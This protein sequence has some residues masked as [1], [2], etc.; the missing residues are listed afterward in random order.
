M[1]GQAGSANLLLGR[2]NRVAMEETELSLKAT[3]LVL[4]P[5]RS[6]VLPIGALLD[7]KR[8]GSGEQ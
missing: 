1:I 6:P 7:I 2:S 5:L 8:T 4:G 3:A